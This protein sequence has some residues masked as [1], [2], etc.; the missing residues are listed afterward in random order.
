MVSRR[1]GRPPFCGGCSPR[2]HSRM[3]ALTVKPPS[4]ASAAHRIASA[5]SGR[6][7][8]W[9]S[10]KPNGRGVPLRRWPALAACWLAATCRSPLCSDSYSA[11]ATRM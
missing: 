11:T 8:T 9:S 3:I 10:A 6:C 4:S 1:Q 5:S 7:V 2:R